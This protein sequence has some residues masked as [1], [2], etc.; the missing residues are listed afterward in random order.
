MRKRYW[1]ME[2]GKE[3]KKDVEKISMETERANKKKN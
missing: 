1:E 2:L 3:I